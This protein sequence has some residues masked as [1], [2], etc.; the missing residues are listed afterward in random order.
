MLV[1]IIRLGFM[2]I[3]AVSIANA[4]PMDISAT[5]ASVDSFVRLQMAEKDIAG[6]SLAVMFHGKIIHAKGYG[7]ANLEH[8][9]AADTNTVYLMASVTKTFVA[10]ATM[11][12][13]EDGKISL[14]DSIGKYVYEI[15]SHWK[16]VTIYQL[17]SHT[18]GIKGSTTWP[19]PCK[20]EL[21]YDNVNYTR[22][23][24]INETACLP[25]AFTP[26][27]KW[28]YSGRGYYVLGMLIE[29]VSGISFEQYLQDNIFTPLQMHDTRMIS[30]ETIIPNRASAYQ[31][32]D[33]QWVNKVIPQDPIVEFADGG[34]MSTVMDMA[35]WDAAL[36]S[37]RLLKKETLELM[38]TPAKIKDGQA[39]YGLGFGTT[40]FNGHKR[41]GHIGRIPGFESAF[42]RFVD[43]KISVIIFMNT[44]LDD[45]QLDMANQIAELYWETK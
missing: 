35:K 15:P 5:N 38:F 43:D 3:V 9:V 23:D 33:G 32:V 34:L 14:N 13:V 40:P 25:L 39:P 19:P 27:E 20:M 2:L 11:M 28:E 26:G 4:Q 22:A 41:V 31:I 1:A 24:V 36:Y 10:V 6:L 17:L 30:N 44:A 29:A 42:T 16:P 21:K 37:E 7:Y 45:G 8:Q 12:M 18:S